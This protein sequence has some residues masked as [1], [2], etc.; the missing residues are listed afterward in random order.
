MADRPHREVVA[1]HQHHRLETVERIP[2]GVGMDGRERAFVTGVHRLEHVE[3]LGASDLADDDP[4]GPHAQ[5]VAHEVADRDL[6]LSFDVLRP[7]L[8]AHYVLLLELELRSV[9]DRDDPVAAGNGGRHRI[10]HRR[11]T[12]ARTTGDQ[13]VEISLDARAEEVGRIL[14]HGVDPDQLGEVEPLLVEP[15]H[16]EQRARE[17]ERRDDRVHTRAV[18]K[19][20]VHQ[21]GRLV[22]P[23]A[24]LADHLRDDPAQL[25]LVR[26]LKIRLRE[27]TVTLDPDLVGPVDH[28]LRDGAISQQP[29][30]RAIPEDVVSDL[31]GDLF[32]VGPREPRLLLELDDDL[33]PDTRAQLAGVRDVCELRTE[34]ADQAEVDAVLDLGEGVADTPR[35]GR[36]VA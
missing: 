29:F 16:S 32:A 28:D 1:G 7:R 18:G 17:G 36:A 14:R 24:H 19:A 5:G 33:R 2:R 10:E 4:V 25:G 6:T 8:E 20:S 12:G 34:L 35:R 13:D 22:D 27:Q 11:L 30:E 23:P 3:R 31:D 9:L 21:R 26:E 15:P